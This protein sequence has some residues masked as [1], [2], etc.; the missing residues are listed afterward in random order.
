MANTGTQPRLAAPLV[1]GDETR[2]PCLGQLPG[3]DESTTLQADGAAHVADLQPVAAAEI[4]ETLTVNQL[5]GNGL[6]PQHF[7]LGQLAVDPL[8]L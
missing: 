5:L 3:Q 8:T 6:V 4:Q 7:L 2:L 1:P